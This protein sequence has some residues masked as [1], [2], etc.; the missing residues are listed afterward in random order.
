MMNSPNSLP[1]FSCEAK[2]SNGSIAVSS[3]DIAEQQVDII[4][5]PSLSSGLKEYLIERAGDLEEQRSKHTRTHH[6]NSMPFITETTAGRLNCK[7]MLF[8]NWSMPGKLADEDFLSESVRFFI[9]KIIQY[10]LKNERRSDRQT[11][12]IAIAMPDS[13]QHDQIIAEEMVD[14]TIEQI[15]QTTTILLNVSFIFLADQQKLYKQFIDI[16]QTLQTNDRTYGNF[17]C[18][19]S[20]ATITLTA[21]NKKHLTQCDKKIKHY[22]ERSMCRQVLSSKCNE[23]NQDVINGFYSYCRE[24]SVLPQLND[25]QQLVLFGPIANVNQAYQKYELTDALVQMRLSIDQNALKSIPNSFKIVLSYAIDDAAI[26][27]QLRTC[28]TNE[29]FFVWMRSDSSENSFPKIDRS[30]L[31]ILCLSTNYFNDRNCIEEAKYAYEKQKNIIPI[32]VEYCQPIRLLRKITEQQ[33]CLPFFGSQ[34][35]FNLQFDKLLLKI[36]QNI[37]CSST[38]SLKSTQWKGDSV[39]LHFLLTSKQRKLI[40]DELVKKLIN[41]KSGRI[42]DDERQILIKQVHNM[43]KDREYL[44]K[45]KDDDK[46]SVAMPDNNNSRHTTDFDHEQKVVTLFQICDTDVL[47]LKQWINRIMLNPTKKNIPPFTYTGD[48]NDAPFPILDIVVQKTYLSADVG[49]YSPMVDLSPNSSRKTSTDNESKL[50]K[51]IKKEETM[52]HDESIHS[53]AVF[54]S[55]IDMKKKDKDSKENYQKKSK[56]D[57]SEEDHQKKKKNKKQYSSRC[58][59]SKEQLQEYKAEFSKRM[60]QN[61]N[62]F[63]KFCQDYKR[64]SMKASGARLKVNITAIFTPSPFSSNVQPRKALET[65]PESNTPLKFLWNGVQDECNRKSRRNITSVF[66][67]HEPLVLDN[68]EILLKDS[69]H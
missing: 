53:D 28:L 60:E 3:G 12:S 1:F 30:D 66:F 4:I 54:I 47:L 29:G 32:K 33:I 56:D 22:F 41:S 39:Q 18:P 21:T 62:S 48:I 2:L 42:K 52:K 64:R 43:I 19:T 11:L 45:E 8:V 34:D 67:S 6:D 15:R 25:Q 26:C 69:I 36:F 27:Q 46:K 59:Y 44:D 7:K 14:E 24:I 38:S 50:R 57:D 5:I 10:V 16:V 68:N 49:S 35:N 51:T 9:S 23:W 37:K 55:G 13:C 40:Y 58:S 31:F 65:R 63:E 17:Y 20:I 61:K